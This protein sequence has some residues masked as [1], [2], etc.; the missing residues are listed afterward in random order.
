[1]GDVMTAVAYTG[2]GFEAPG[3]SSFYL[4][5][6]DEANAG[7]PVWTYLLCLVPAYEHARHY[8]GSAAGLRARLRQHGTSDGARLLQVQRQADGAFVLAR[9]WPG[10]RDVEYRL[11]G[12]KNSPVLCPRCTPGTQR[13]I[14]PVPA[15]APTPLFPLA[16]SRTVEIPGGLLVLR[17]RPV[18]ATSAARGRRW[19]RQF[20]AEREGWAADEIEQAAAAFQAPYYEGRRTPEGDALNGAFGRVIERALAALRA[21]QEVPA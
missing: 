6:L 8:L 4:P 16:M 20:L 9:T 19:A 3:V 5:H 14:L 18:L 21:P 10:G 17:A 7:V 1:M 12:R 13:G 15:Q 11:K 2:T